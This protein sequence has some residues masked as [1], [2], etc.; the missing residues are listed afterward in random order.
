MKYLKSYNESRSEKSYED[1]KNV[2]D[3]LLELKDLRYYVTAVESPM[4]LAMNYEFPSIFVMIKDFEYIAQFHN[5]FKMPVIKN[6]GLEE[7]TKL[8]IIDYMKSEGYD[9]YKQFNWERYPI[10]ISNGNREPY[11]DYCYIDMKFWKS[12]QDEKCLHDYRNRQ[13]R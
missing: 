8:R 6:K 7:E 2:E 11:K 10:Y 13:S 1:I 5:Y 9:N 4:E 12:D 3:I